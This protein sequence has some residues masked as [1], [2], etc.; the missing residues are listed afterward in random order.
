MRL[1]RAERVERKL[2]EKLKR[3]SERL[4]ALEKGLAQ[5]SEAADD[6]QALFRAALNLFRD[7]TGAARLSLMLL[8]K[9][10]EEGELRIVEARGLS[11][12]VVANTRLRLG[13]RVAGW[14]AKHGRMLLRT[15]G[16]RPAGELPQETPYS[17]D[18]FLSLPLK[19]GADVVGVVNMTEG[20]SESALE[21]PQ[22]QSLSVLARQAAVWIRYCERLQQARQLSLVDELTGLYNR[23]Y[24]MDA[25][26]REISRARRTGEQL[27]LA[28]LDIDHFKLYNDK[29]GHQ[30]GDR[31]LAEFARIIRSNVRATDIVCRYGGEEFAIILPETGKADSHWPRVGAHFIDRLRAAVA[32]Y[33]FDG[34]DAQPGGRLTVSAGV[35]TFPADAGDAK[36]LIA[37]ADRMLYKAKRAGR[38]RVCSTSDER[39]KG[40]KK[41]Q[42]S[43]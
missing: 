28:M 9:T 3:Q 14:V 7:A 27:G 20:L 1:R 22:V 36:G 8:E 29:H 13:E 19:A 38:N 40:Q 16:G 17:T 37:A 21:R 31:L 12:E 30:A 32:D 41:Q 25:L 10:G 33:P 23:R 24:L 34:E 6:M 11:E 18:A 2:R 43:A 4:A 15:H 26:E 39:R 42:K 35:A 5:L